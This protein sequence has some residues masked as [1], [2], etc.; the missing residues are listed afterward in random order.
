[1]NTTRLRRARASERGEGYLRLVVFLAVLIILAY[2]AF[3]NVPTYFEVQN[4]EHDLAELVRGT[5]VINL[6]V[7]RIQPQV[8]KIADQ[9]NVPMTDIKLE[10]SGKT[11]KLTLNTTRQIDLIVTTY[12]WQIS[13]TYTQISY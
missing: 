7:E 11:T 2:L 12:D 9:Y 10:K 6:P 8:K 4:L 5:G 13:K 1:M 3:Q